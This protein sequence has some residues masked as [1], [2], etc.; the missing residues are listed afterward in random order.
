MSDS[1]FELLNDTDEKNLV[2]FILKEQVKL[3]GL[4]VNK[5]KEKTENIFDVMVD[6]VIRGTTSNENSRSGLSGFSAKYLSDYSDNPFLSRFCAKALYY[7][8]AVAEENAR[9]GKI[10]ACPTAGSSGIIPGVF[11]SYFEEFSPDKADMVNALIVSGEIGRIIALKVAPAGAV[12]GCQAECGTAAA[13]AAGG[14]CYLQKCNLDTIINSVALTVKNVLGLTCD[15]VAGLVEVPCIKRNAYLA[16]CAIT[17]FHLASSG[18]KSI[19]PADECIDAM[20][21]TG[22]IMSPRLKESS[23]AG[24]AVT[25]TGIRIK[26]ELY[27]T[28]GVKNCL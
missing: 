15:P 2:D 18:I 9:M 1:F 28:F 7:S 16:Q 24:L 22:A 27:K 5:I 4:C 23:E 20:A 19:I 17:S 12:A 13:M 3:T 10:A 14:L 26:D 25:K 21:E 6:S 8:V 11:V